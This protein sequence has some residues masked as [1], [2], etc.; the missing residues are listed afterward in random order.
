M[1]AAEITA[2]DYTDET[3]QVIRFKIDG[4]DKEVAAPSGNIWDGLIVSKDKKKAFFMMKRGTTK[5]AWLEGLQR[6]DAEPAGKS[7]NP[8]A[9]PLKTDLEEAKILKIHD[10]SDDGARLLVDLHYAYEKTA[11]RTRYR[12]Y[13]YFLTADGVLTPVKP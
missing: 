5:R 4:V 1:N 6:F 8:S 13:P 3:Q 10:V 7:S 11:D 12:S 2:A 9:V